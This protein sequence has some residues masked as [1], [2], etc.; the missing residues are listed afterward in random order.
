VPAVGCG[1]AF[2]CRRGPGLH[3][4]GDRCA[5]V[6]CDCLLVVFGAGRACYCVP[7][8]CSFRPRHADMG[9]CVCASLLSEGSDMARLSEEA[10]AELE[11]RV[12]VLRI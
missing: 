3:T 2:G 6:G 5:A 10:R 9:G 11:R 1:H 12:E 4:G 7:N 8:I